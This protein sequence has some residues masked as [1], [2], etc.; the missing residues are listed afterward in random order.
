MQD[1]DLS[2]DLQVYPEQAEDLFDALEAVPDL[3][4][5]VDHAGGFWDRSEGSYARWL[6]AMRQLA[7]RENTYVKL[8]GWGMYRPDWQP[9][10]L[11][12]RVGDLI[13]LFHSSRVMWGSNYPVEKL[14]TPY[15][16][17][18][19]AFRRAV[20]STDHEDV[21]HRVAA[22]VYRLTLDQMGDQPSA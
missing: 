20:G 3:T 19:S 7:E 21:F 16:A 6:A 4:V 8:S 5:I 2:F 14:V 15:P 22:R 11:N 18:L 9:D 17:L 10:D 13:A 1:N 12:P